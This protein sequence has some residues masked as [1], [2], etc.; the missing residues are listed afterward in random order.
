MLVQ[1]QQKTCCFDEHIHLGKDKTFWEKLREKLENPGE[2]A[3]IEWIS[4]VSKR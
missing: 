4:V 2:I 3:H 1:M